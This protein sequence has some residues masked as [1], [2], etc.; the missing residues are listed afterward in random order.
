MVDGFSV[1]LDQCHELSQSVAQGRLQ[2]GE[3]GAIGSPKIQES[4]AK[5]KEKEEENS[6][7]RTGLYSPLRVTR[8]L[9]TVR[10]ACQLPTANRL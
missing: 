5:E 6:G 3:A 2:V 9:K 8:R 1:L 10:K 4:K 7:F